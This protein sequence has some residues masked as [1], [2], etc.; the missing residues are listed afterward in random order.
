M[1]AG[2]PTEA[3]VR[4]LAEMRLAALRTCLGAAESIARRACIRGVALDAFA[5]WIANARDELVLPRQKPLS[6][7]CCG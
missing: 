4:A 7:R 6:F 1:I 3:R 2:D 5:D